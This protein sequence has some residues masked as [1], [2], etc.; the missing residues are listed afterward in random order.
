M[1]IVSCRVFSFFSYFIRGHAQLYNA[2]PAGYLTSY[3]KG[4]PER[5]LAKCSTYLKDGAQEPIT[6]EFC[7]SY[8]AAYNVRLW[9]R[10]TGNMTDTLH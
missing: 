4:A 10:H 2:H 8:D 3:I 6:D 1:V 7:A 9:F 5:I